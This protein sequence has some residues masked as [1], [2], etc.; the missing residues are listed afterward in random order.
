MPDDIAISPISSPKFQTVTF[1]RPWRKYQAIL[2]SLLR[3][4]GKYTGMRS[5]MRIKNSLAGG[6]FHGR[7]RSRFA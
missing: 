2:I 4:S 5:S 1:I 6:M 7:N 3:I